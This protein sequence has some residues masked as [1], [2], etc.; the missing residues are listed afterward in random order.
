[1]PHLSIRYDHWTTGNWTLPHRVSQAWD[2][3]RASPAD[4]YIRSMGFDSLLVHDAANWGQCSMQALMQH[5]SD[6]AAALQGH[7]RNRRVLQAQATFTGVPAFAKQISRVKPLIAE[8]T[9]EMPRRDKECG[10]QATKPTPTDGVE[11]LEECVTF[12]V[13]D[14]SFCFFPQTWESWDMKSAHKTKKQ[15]DCF[16]ICFICW[17]WVWCSRTLFEDCLQRT[18]KIMWTEGMQNNRYLTDV[19]DWAEQG[20]GAFPPEQSVGGGI[21]IRCS[22]LVAVWRTG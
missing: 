10:Q 12:F 15:L 14:F 17:G 21:S 1:M 2:V 11:A 8:G 9:A 4:S 16:H 22:E 3:W 6:T 20:N 5:F 13:W 7:C 19:W 18:N